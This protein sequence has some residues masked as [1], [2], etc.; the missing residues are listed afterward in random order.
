[1]KRLHFLLALVLMSTNLLAQTSILG[2]W[3]T[4]DDKTGEKKSVVSI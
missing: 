2:E 3:I 1:M 4:V